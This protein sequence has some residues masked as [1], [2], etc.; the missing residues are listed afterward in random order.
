MP[1]LSSWRLCWRRWFQDS[2]SL[3]IRLKLR[4]ID[5]TKYMGI[6]WPGVKSTAANLSDK[7]VAGHIEILCRSGLIVGRGDKLKVHKG[8]DFSSRQHGGDVKKMGY[9]LPDLLSFSWSAVLPIWHA[10]FSNSSMFHCSGSTG[11][12]TL[13]PLWSSHRQIPLQSCYPYF[14]TCLCKSLNKFLLPAFLL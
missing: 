12:H 5:T 9:I 1:P 3:T 6:M 4:Y 11:D 7:G 2:M 13:C 10:S 14:G 8:I